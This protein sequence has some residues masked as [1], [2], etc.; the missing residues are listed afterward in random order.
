MS[1]SNSTEKH[2]NKVGD[3]LTDVKIV[4]KDELYH[5][6]VKGMK[7]GVRR[8]TKK[9][10][11]LTTKAR[12]EVVKNESKR[13]LKAYNKAADDMNNGLID[14]YNAD[15]KK[16]IGDKAKDRDP[17]DYLDDSEYMEGYNKMFSDRLSKYYNKALLSEITNNT[18]YKKAKVL[19]DK[20][21]LTKYDD[22]AREREAEIAEMRKTLG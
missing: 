6:G 4:H 14:K 19:C 18:N 9:Y 17:F 13:Y 7:W 22:F 2:S 16:K 12:D 8:A 5:Y 3:N 15:Y 21:N 20:Y 10:T 1:L 11:K